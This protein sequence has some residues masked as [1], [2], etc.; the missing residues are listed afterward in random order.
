MTHMLSGLAGGKVVVA[1]E[2]NI[3]LSFLH[4]RAESITFH[5]REVT[6][7]TRYP[8]LRLQSLV[9]FSAKPLMNY[10]P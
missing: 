5:L 6:I 9:F 7:S 2:V 10:R 3:A 4:H 8:N 1:L